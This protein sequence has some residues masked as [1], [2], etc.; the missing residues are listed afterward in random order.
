MSLFIAVLLT[1]QV[2]Y[3]SVG[4]FEAFRVPLTDVQYAVLATGVINV[5][6]TIISVR[7]TNSNS[8]STQFKFT[9]NTF[10]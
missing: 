7:T 2:V 4:I 9:V 10:T 5:I 6:M 1:F 3:Y 8:I